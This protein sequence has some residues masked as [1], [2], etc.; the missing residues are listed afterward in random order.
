MHKHTFTYIHTYVRTYGHT[1][2]HSYITLLYFTLLYITL[3]YVTLHYITL[4]YITLHYIKLHYITLHYITLHYNTLQ[5]SAVQYITY[6]HICLYVYMC[7][8][9]VCRTTTAA[10]IVSVRTDTARRTDRNNGCKTPFLHSGLTF[11]RGQ[12][13]LRSILLLCS[14]CRSC[15]GLVIPSMTEGKARHCAHV[16]TS[17][18]IVFLASSCLGAKGFNYTDIHCTHLCHEASSPLSSVRA[19]MAA[20]LLSHAGAQVEWTRPA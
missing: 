11:S 16:C 1:Y 6:L 13:M 20:G 18:G 9:N 4:H 7:I 17:F 12:Y 5:Y 2:I 10:K 14:P 19:R 8:C 15:S 3:H